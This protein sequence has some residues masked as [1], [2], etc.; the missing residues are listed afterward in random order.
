MESIIYIQILKA[1][2]F[3]FLMFWE[4][5]W[6][7]VLGF[8]LSAIV[9]A[10]VP[11]KQISRLLPDAKLKSLSTATALGAA[12]SSC[13]YAAVALTRSIIQ[14][15]ANFVAGM[16]FQ[17][18]STNL[19]VE[20]SIIM[21]ILLGWQFFMAEL[22][23]GI[24]LVAIM[25][26]LF[27]T[28]V[29][30]KQIATAVEHANAGILGKMEGHAAMD[31]ALTEGPILQRIFSKKGITVISHFFIMDWLAI[32][33]DIV[34]GIL[35]AG[36]LAAWVPNDFWASFFLENHPTISKVWGPFVGPIVAI[37]SFVCSI[38]NVPLAAVLWQHGISFGGVIA[39]IYADLIII[40]ILHIYYKYYGFKMACIIFAVYYTAIVIASIIVDIVFQFFNIVPKNKN[41]II[42]EMNIHFNYTT[43]LNIIFGFIMI[44]LIYYFF[45]T[46]G[47]KMIRM[48]DKM[49]KMP[50]MDN[51]NK[52]NK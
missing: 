36:A 13:S 27:K 11:K 35:I 30:K 18:A 24:L 40:P 38:G 14:K 44:F 45:K 28:F 23:G 20:L 51:M 49:D 12:S 15:G 8:S 37:F 4:I 7:L 9:Q 48:M 21:I 34:L 22:V 17:M 3:A 10:V 31:M 32:W 43:V 6:A 46:N 33:K 1:L 5:F 25:S 2:E 26:V 47:L 41:I 16:A 50:K 39:F 29:Q 42:N 19:V 52:M